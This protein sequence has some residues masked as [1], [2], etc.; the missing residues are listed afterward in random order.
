M[1]QILAE[2]N[3]VSHKRSSPAGTSR[4][5]FVARTTATSAPDGALGGDAPPLGSLGNSSAEFARTP[6]FVT[7]LTQGI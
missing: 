7:A 4:S 6:I 1:T 5:A 2:A 3:P